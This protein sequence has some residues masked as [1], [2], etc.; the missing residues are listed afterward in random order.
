M[1]GEDEGANSGE[2]AAKGESPAG[3]GAPKKKGRDPS[4]YNLVEAAQYG[5]LE[6]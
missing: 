1:R 6:R 4:R 5:Y 3:G 2:S